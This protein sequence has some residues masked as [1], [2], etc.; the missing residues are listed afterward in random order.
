MALVRV[1]DE[2]VRAGHG[3]DD[4]HRGVGERLTWRHIK[5]FWQA[6]EERRAE[7]LAGRLTEA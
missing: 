6:A 1:F 2:L 3:G 4:G 7:A 5:L